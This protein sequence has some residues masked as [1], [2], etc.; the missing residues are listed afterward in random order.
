MKI[1]KHLKIE[2]AC[3]KEKERTNIAAP[4]L[5][6]SNGTDRLVSTNG[7]ILAAVPVECDDSD[8][9]GYV[10][11]ACLKD[12]RKAGFVE[13]N[14]AAKV[15]GTSF[16]R[17]TESTFPNWR[18]VMPDYSGEKTVKVAIDPALLKALAEAMGAEALILEIPIGYGDGSRD[19][20]VV[21]PLSVRPTTANGVAPYET[22]ARGV[23][24]PIRIK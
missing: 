18:A 17:D 12:A 16:N 4:Y 8:T 10:P 9:S 7:R 2:S 15:G 20:S 23:I 14:G 6:R 3:S 13:L 1:H 21:R 5:D 24:M 19:E 11:L 22:D